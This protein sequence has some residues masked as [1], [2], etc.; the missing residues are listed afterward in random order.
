M[1]G[2][3]ADEAATDGTGETTAPTDQ[4]G[5]NRLGRKLLLAFAST[6]LLVAGCTSDDEGGADDRSGQD[7]AESDPAGDTTSTP[8]RGTDVAAPVL[9][10]PVTGGS[11]DGHPANPA[12]PELLEEYGYL[13]EEYF[14]SGDATSYAPVGEL[15]RDGLWE[16]E[17][18]G[19]APYTTRIL[20]RRPADPEDANG[21]VAVEWLNVSG[22]QDADPDFG[23]LAP[24]LLGSGTTWIG[25]S[26]QFSGVDGPGLGIEIPGVQAIPLKTAD[27]VRY[28]PIQHPG[29]AFSYDIYSQVA[30]AVRQPGDTDLLGG[31]DVEHVIAI[32]ESQSAARLTTYVNAVHPLADIYD[33]FLVHS[34]SGAAALSEEVEPP[35]VVNFRTDLTD[36]ILWFQT[37]TDVARAFEARQPDTEHLVT[38]EL[39]GAAHADQSQLDYGSASIRVIEPDFPLPDFEELCG[40]TLNQGPQPLVLQRAFAD[41][42]AWVAEGT[43]PAPA[44]ELDIEDGELVRDEL[45]IATGGIRT[46]DVDVPIAVHSGVPR[47]DASVICVLF[48][49][50]TPLGPEVIAS[51]YPSKQDYVDRVRESA[52]AAVEAGYLLP[53]GA[54]EF[55]AEAEQVELS[56]WE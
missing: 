34:R 50:T 12:P 52:D 6:V 42:L 21:V 2:S 9:E 14:I 23:F 11:R 25:V 13:E 40:G 48:G 32:G 10:G 19:E 28:E 22:G 30:Q 43:P 44:Q 20:V 36:P 54:D 55:V 56:N 29:D 5:S 16:V 26:A 24:E 49:S 46:P 51:L 38:W 31:I 17:A 8:A 41:L 53:A 33:G 7:T 37:E 27:P 45:G 18:A 39:A 3:P 4:N 35:E 47:E 1:H 15:T